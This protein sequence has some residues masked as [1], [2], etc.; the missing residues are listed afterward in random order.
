LGEAERPAQDDV[1]FDGHAIE[2]RLYAEDPAQEFLPQT[3]DIALWRAAEDDSAHA[4]TPGVR[5]DTGVAS[6]Q[7]VSPFYDPMIA[8]VMAHGPDRDTARRRLVTALQ[9][10]R[11]AGLTT[12]KSFLIELLED[13]PFVAGEATTGTIGERFPAERRATPSLSFDDAALG[14]V[15]LH[16]RGRERAAAKAISIPPQLL[17]WSTQASAA[18]PFR[19]A[20]E[21][22]NWELTVRTAPSGGRGRYLVEATTGERAE[23][24]ILEGD[25]LDLLV[26]VD[27]GP[28]Q[29]IGA[30]LAPGA[31][32]GGAAAG[33]LHL[34]LG[35]RSHRLRN[36]VGLGGGEDAAS[37]GGRVAAPMHGRIVEVLVAEGE[38]V[39]KGQRLVVLEAMKMQHAVE[40]EVDG[41]V[42]VVSCAVDDQVAADDL[43][44][45]IEPA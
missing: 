38:T 37:G 34:D 42:T 16:R 35:R 6:G 32:S 31:L 9:D 28:R 30:W 25:A 12:N 1:R 29:R 17:D 8:K 40:A 21:P 5:V 22:Q 23:I 11:V 39:S 3:G 36:L 14:A 45:E 27:G 33:E 41:A 7:A 18:T 13:A 15:A 20:A 19:F 10:T 43:L 26:E 24:A 2:A 4:G 44:V